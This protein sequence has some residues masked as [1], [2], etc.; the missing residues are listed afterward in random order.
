MG[1]LPDNLKVVTGAYLP[2]GHLQASEPVLVNQSHNV[3]NWYIICMMAEL[4][5]STAVI[6]ERGVNMAYAAM[7]PS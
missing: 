2:L 7:P 5:L 4:Q 6:L 3:K 1:R